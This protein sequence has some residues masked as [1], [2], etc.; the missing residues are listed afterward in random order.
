M[1]MWAVIAVAA[2]W[3]AVIWHNRRGVA[4]HDGTGDPEA[5]IIVFVEPV[6]WLFIDWGFAGTCGGLRRAGLKH[7]IHLFHWSRWAGSLLVLPDL[8]RRGRLDAKAARLGRFLQDLAVNHPRSMIH[9]IG[10]SSGAYVAFEAIKTLPADVRLGRVIILHGTVSPGYDLG[11]VAARAEIL[12]VFGWNDFV[13]NGV[14]P[15]L[16]GTNDRV[17]AFACG[18][19]GFRSDVG[20][21]SQRRWCRA[22]IRDGYWGDHFTVVSG[23]WICRNIGPLLK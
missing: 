8:M 19:V 16:F 5:G 7:A 4:R 9:L 21:L 2:I 10:Y 11:P 20:G 14:G 6:R 12:N 1:W 23:A 13:I 18:M 22:D 17:H 15:L 3:A